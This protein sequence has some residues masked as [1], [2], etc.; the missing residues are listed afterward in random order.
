MPLEVKEWFCA[1]ARVKRDWTMTQCL[2]FAKRALPSFFEHARIDTTA[3]GS[4]KTSGITLGRPRSLEPAV[5]LALADIVSR[6]SNRVCCGAGV[7]A[8]L[9][10]AKPGDT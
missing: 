1:L 4:Q 5:V 10:N 7:L 3:S 2:R 8:E 9:L 6:V